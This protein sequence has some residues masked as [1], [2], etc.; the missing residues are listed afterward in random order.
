MAEPV[1][2][3]CAGRYAPG[4]DTC[5]NCGLAL[6]TPTVDLSSGNPQDW[7]DARL[8]P[9]C[10]KPVSPGD[11]SCANCGFAVPVSSIVL[12]PGTLLKGRYE[13][14]QFMHA[15][16]MSFVYLARDTNL[17]DR[18]CV[19]KQMR[20]RVRAHDQQKR[21]EEEAMRMA[22]LSHP[23]IATIFDHFVEDERYF[24]VVEHIRGKTLSEVLKGK[25][26]RLE[27]SEVL[28]WGISMCEVIAYLHDEGIIHRD[29]SPDNVMITDDGTVKF[30][31]FGTL[32]DSRYASAGATAGMG[33]YGYAPPEQ[34]RGNPGP[35]SDIFALGATLYYLLTGFLPLSEAYQTQHAP[36]EEDTNPAFPPIRTKNPHVSRMLESTLQKALELESGQRFASAT[37]MGEALART[38]R[39]APRHPSNQ[40]WRNLSPTQRLILIAGAGVGVGMLGAGI[41]MVMLAIQK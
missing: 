18:L 13:I 29:I 30:I 15:G 4:H 41:Y 36:Q 40:L 14:Q 2:P 38:R 1:C 35:R 16:G 37:E 32:R 28:S 34:W 5:P 12:S 7:S 26:G 11:S 19:V 3:N 9:N 33:K 22:K 8:C 20:E 24:I 39:K 31:D 25:Q 17:F 27:E 10:G 6:S 23:K 21:L